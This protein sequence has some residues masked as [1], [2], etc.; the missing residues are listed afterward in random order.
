MLLPT[1]DVDQLVEILKTPDE[2]A[3]QALLNAIGY[4]DEMATPQGMDALLRAAIYDG[5]RFDAD[6][7]QTPADIAVQVWLH[8]HKIVEE[9][10]T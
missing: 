6:A 4:I 1:L 10:Q 5:M 9:Q 8:D 7:D 2:E 3:P